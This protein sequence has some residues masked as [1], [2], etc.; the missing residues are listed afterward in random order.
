LKPTIFPAHLKRIPKTSEEQVSDPQYP[1][2]K[3]SFGNSPTEEQRAKL[4]G[5]IELT[6][7]SL[8]NAVAG[9]T[10]QQIETPYRDGGWTVRQVVHHV[11]DSHINAYV[12]FKLA[13]TEEEPTIK[14]YA[15][16]R[17]AR[18][19]DSRSTPIETS[20]SLLDS[21]HTRWV[22]L[23]R[24]IKPEE[25]KR[26][27][28]HPELGLVSLERNLALYSWHGRHHVAHITE[29]RRRMSW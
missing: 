23:L 3:F 18:L 4:I 19:E 21:L 16:D 5:D 8:R 6:P 20:L 12:R 7:A 14:G 2:G 29:L 27:F 28:H 22:R 13:L 1:I 17:W 10:S 24:S 26:T 9:L 11:P 15:E 25:W